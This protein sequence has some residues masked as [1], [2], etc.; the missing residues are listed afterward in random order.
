M[1][2]FILPIIFCLA[3]TCF[4]TYSFLDTFII[5][6]KYNTPTNSN[7]SSRVFSFLEM[8]DSSS[9]PTSSTSQ[10]TSEQ[11]SSVP[12]LSS[13]EPATNE[14]QYY[15]NLTKE[16]ISALF[17]QEKVFELS[18][19]RKRYSDPDIYVDITTD[20]FE[21]AGN[22]Y[23]ADIRLRS[24]KY[25]KTALA[26]D[27][28]GENYKEKTSEMC[29]R[30]KGIIAIDGDTYGSQKNGYVIR[31][32]SIIRST[33]N[34][35]RK[36]PEDLAIYPNGTFEIFN[37]NDYTLDQIAN[38]GAWHV[39]SFGPGLVDKGQKIIQKGEEVGTAAGG[40]RNQ[41][42]AIGMIAPLHYVFVVSDGRIAESLGLSL[43]QMGKIMQERLHCYTA[44]NLDGGGSATMYF[45]DGTGGTAGALINVCTQENTGGFRPSSNPKI[46]EREVSDIVYIG[47]E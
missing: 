38:K 44:Y 1:K 35:S 5:P 22:Y 28:A 34:T 42:C 37:E 36:K 10:N 21:D 11:S 25:F 40:N 2:K 12:T 15:E 30:H 20:R 27:T 8:D 29:I 39:F 47:K 23:V 19:T 24:F 7:S 4:V 17:T 9:I 33:K 32:G 45:D 6:K 31:N 41:R 13:T 3:G 26:H 16:E 46:E 14:G 18:E 43:Y